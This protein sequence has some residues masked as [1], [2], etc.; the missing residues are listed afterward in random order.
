MDTKEPE[1]K[2]DSAPQGEAQE[3]PNPN[4]PQEETLQEGMPKGVNREPDAVTGDDLTPPIATGFPDPTDS[5]ITGGDS[6]TLGEPRTPVEQQRATQPRPFGPIRAPGD[7]PGT[8]PVVYSGPG[9]V[10]S[11]GVVFDPLRHAT[12]KDGSPKRD[13]RGW[14]YSNRAGK[15][16]AK[17]READLSGNAD[18][19]P[20]AQAPAQ[21]IGPGAADPNLDPMQRPQGFVDSN[22]VAAEAYCQNV[23]ALA[24]LYF[25]DKGWYPE[26][27][28]EHETMKEGVRE[29]LTAYDIPA[30]SPWQKL[31]V[32]STGY[33]S[34]RA[35]RPNTKEKL[36]LLWVRVRGWIGWK[37]KAD[38]QAEADAE[39]EAQ[40]EGGGR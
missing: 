36:I 16:K 31:L 2:P 15:P 10:D 26:S 12:K 35:T 21:G 7:K 17:Q 6:E 40:A 30:L 33:A 1:L 32:L 14:F 18:P 9:E 29:C 23:Y 27:E 25:N 8:P 11:K 37:K 5:P 39:A 38:A 19:M 3:K 28:L 22:S 13:K 34:K 20:Q 4:P 24:S